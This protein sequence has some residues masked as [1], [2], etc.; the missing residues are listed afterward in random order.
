MAE[1]VL[2]EVCVDSPSSAIAAERGGAARVE[3]CGSLAEGGITPSAG[4]IEAVRKKISIGLQVIIRPRPGDFCYEPDEVEIMCRDISLAKE[5]GADGVVFG[6][7]DREGKVDVGTT[8]ELVR[9]AHPMNVT[10][11]R[12]FDMSADLF[13]ALED[14]CAAGAHRVLTSG[15]EKECAQGAGTIARLVK[16]AQ[17]RVAIMAGGG[18]RQD[19]VANI[20]QSTGVQEIHV[21]LSR[22]VASPMT[23]RNSR[24]SLGKAE[25]REYQRWQV[26]EENVRKLQRSLA[27]G[28]S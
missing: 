10:F 24:V 27:L 2:I 19:N 25:G 18:V 11:H 1:I 15:G 12:A 9:L 28:T 17:G 3:L 6:I 8:G 22:L 26:L 7:L 5:A 23:Y 4:M 13:Q 20:I 16:A 14:V 21:G